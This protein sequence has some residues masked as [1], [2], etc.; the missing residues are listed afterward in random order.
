MKMLWTF[1][2]VVL[3]LCLAIPVSFFVLTTAIGILGA[4]VGLAALAIRLAIVGV[5]VWGAYRLI[6]ALVGGRSETTRPR[7]I[8]MPRVDPYYEAAVKEV[9][10]DIG[11]VK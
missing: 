9:D 2:K 1:V 3:V 8:A 5:V 6:K 7:E 11:W 10:R 4:L